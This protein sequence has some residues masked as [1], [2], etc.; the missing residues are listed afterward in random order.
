MREKEYKK[1]LFQ[2]SNPIRKAGLGGFQW[3]DETIL[4]E[5][6][7]SKSTSLKPKI[8]RYLAYA[9]AVAYTVLNVSIVSLSWIP[10]LLIVILSAGIWFFQLDKSVPQG[11]AL[12]GITIF[13]IITVSFLSGGIDQQANQGFYSL[14]FLS[15]A[16]LMIL[17]TERE[18]LLLSTIM[19]S[20]TVG[21]SE[22]LQVVFSFLIVLIFLLYSLKTNHT[23]PWITTMKSRSLLDEP[24]KM[25]LGY[26]SVGNKLFKRAIKSKDNSISARHK[27]SV[28]E[29]RTAYELQKLPKGSTVIHDVKLPGAQQAN[30]DHIAITNR[31]VF[32]I[33]TKLFNGYLYERGGKL[34]KDHN[35]KSQSLDKVTQ[36]MR[37]AKS[38]IQKYVKDSEVKVIVAVQKGI[39]DGDYLVAKE[40]KGGNVAYTSLE[41]VQSLIMKF[42]VILE[43]NEQEEAVRSLNPIASKR[44]S[45]LP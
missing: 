9:T 23:L 38:S 40:K 27:G 33:D 39:V 41:N 12:Y 25:P 4:E 7:K 14:L 3:R 36:Q 29:R 28:A 6:K 10:L 34:L 43:E 21:K 20:G 11:K 44:F 1:G 30:I 16:L 8:F 19:L 5:L 45:M 15:C 18:T 42:P 31:G 37:W 26:Y 22:F 13:L 2:L 35:G 32:V 24:L 17:T